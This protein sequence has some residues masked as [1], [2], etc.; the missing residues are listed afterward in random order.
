MAVNVANLVNLSLDLATFGHSNQHFSFKKP[1][2]VQQ[3]T[4]NLAKS[5]AIRYFKSQY[6]PIRRSGLP[7]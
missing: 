5:E 4:T 3:L 6:V 2:R 7:R 1:L